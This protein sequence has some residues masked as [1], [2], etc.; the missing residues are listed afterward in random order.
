MGGERGQVEAEFTR[1]LGQFG[2]LVRGIALAV[3]SVFGVLATPASA[4]PLAFAL[5]GLALAGGAAD[6]YHAVTGRA[7]V[8]ACVLTCGRAVAICAAQPWTVPGLWAPN[9]LTITGI[10]VQWQWPLRVTVPVVTGLLALEAA[11]IGVGEAAP[12]LVRVVIE[13]TLARLAFALLLRVTRWIER[14]RDRQTALERAGTLALE[15]RRQD[16]EY[17]AL[18]HDTASATFLMV[19][20]HRVE[21]AAVAGYARR[22]L[23]VLTGE[24]G[25]HDSLVD[26]EA[27]LR[28]IAAQSPLDTSIEWTP[29]PL[30]PASAA[31]ALTRAVR[32]ALRNVERHAGVARARITVGSHRHGAV[33]TVADE[34]AGFDPAAVPGQRRGIRGSL[35]E[36]MA[37]AGGSA[38]V[39]S[40]PGAGTTVRLAWPDV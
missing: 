39:T 23:A 3:L 10:T 26:L 4:L 16:R 37:A 20:L 30:L 9:V 14:I 19:A 7:G 28:G 40:R 15:R 36:R 25:A 2:G 33:I 35:V 34:G 8:L 13:S 38:T 27:S 29:V 22:D 17:L 18:L 21:P 5:L 32:E 1:A 31:L 12:V 24:R 11:V 6:C